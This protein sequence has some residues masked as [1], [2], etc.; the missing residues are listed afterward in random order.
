[1]LQTGDY[2]QAVLK[3]GLGLD[4]GCKTGIV[5]LDVYCA[6]VTPL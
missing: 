4:G 6:A 1:M 5:G 2:V 3:Q